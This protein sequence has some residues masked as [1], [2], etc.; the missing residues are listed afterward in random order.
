[1]KIQSACQAGENTAIR[2][3]HGIA[4]LQPERQ[5]SQT[6][7]AAPLPPSPCSTAQ[8]LSRDSIRSGSI[9]IMARAL[10]PVFLQAIDGVA[11]D[12]L[13]NLRLTGGIDALRRSIDHEL[14]NCGFTPDWLAQWLSQDAVFLAR[15]FVELTGAPR[16]RLR[17]ETVVDDACRRFHPDNV[18]FRLVTTYRGPGTEW[19]SPRDATTTP[20]GAELLDARIRRL[21][22]GHVAIMRGCRAA[23]AD[24]PALLHRS[25]PIA[26]SGVTRLFLAIDEGADVE[27][28]SRG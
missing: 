19:I 27:M 16:L 14:K 26:G 8:R 6:L 9:G 15:V 20:S 25:P 12:R 5:K 2:S 11:G 4:S 17:L 7:P 1:M 3:Q 24:L 22:R 23:T 13:P 28:T 18:R 10:D 21:D